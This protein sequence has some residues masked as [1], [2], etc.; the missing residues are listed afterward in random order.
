[1]I[2]AGVMGSSIAL[3]LA[4]AGYEVHIIDRNSGPGLGSTSASSAVVRFN[5]STLDAV[6][7]SWESYFLWKDWKSLIDGTDGYGKNPFV[8]S[9]DH[10][11]EMVNR[12]YVMLDVPIL[13]NAKTEKLFQEAGIPYEIWSPS[14]L[15]SNMPGIDAGQYWPNKPVKSDEFWN[16]ASRELGGIFSNSGGYIS[17]PL[18]ATENLAFAAKRE[19]AIFHLRKAVIE[20]TKDSHN[21]RVNGVVMR[22]FD[23]TSKTVSGV[24]ESLSADV[25]VNVAGPWSTL[26]NRL[27]GAGNDFT[28]E[29]KPLRQEVHQISTPKDILPGPILGDLDLGTYMR[30]GPGGVTLV[31]GT[32]PEC[33]PMYWVD[34]EK[35]DEVNMT[36]TVEVFESQTYRLARRFPAAQIPSTPTG[37][38][39][40]Y[41]V[42]TDW[43][44][45]YDKTDVPG[46]YVA[47]GTSGNQFKNAP[48]VGFVMT[49]LINQVEAGANHDE[50]PVVYFCQKAKGSISL[51][52]FSRKREKN[53]DSSGTVMG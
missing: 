7:L 6:L 51:G 8:D 5:Y 52:T 48:G 37:V 35:I 24:P 23:S 30:S 32:E 12:G 2:G 13:S 4:R 16:D 38:V 10:Y 25:I 53:A 17:D 29:I 21:G 34:P 41:D 20:I 15:K 19:G 44:P 36:R 3:Q 26:I 49:H 11:A 9:R 27:A 43:T 47:I 50:N 1:M 22:D 18:L 40:I 39:G 42:T 46:F 14:Q 31:G 33:D 28:V 45:I